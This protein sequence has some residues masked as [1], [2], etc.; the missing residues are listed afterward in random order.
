MAVSTLD[1]TFL[2]ENFLF[3]QK[4][5]I[6]VF[7][8]NRLVCDADFVTNFGPISQKLSRNRKACH[9]SP[10]KTVTSFMDDP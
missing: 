1:Q 5:L 9:R 3:L 7:V 8:Q 6:A 10:P 4:F 2:V